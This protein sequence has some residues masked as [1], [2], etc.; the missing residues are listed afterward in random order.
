MTR[1]SCVI[2][3]GKMLAQEVC[4][5]EIIPRYASDLMQADFFCFFCSGK[6][7]QGPT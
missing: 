7:H 2:A 3:N 1:E 6:G 5:T 4:E